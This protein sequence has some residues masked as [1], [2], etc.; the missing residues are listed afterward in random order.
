M[1]SE[2]QALGLVTQEFPQAPFPAGVVL[3][4][5]SALRGG[6]VGQ[7][8]HGP[9]RLRRIGLG[10]VASL[11][12]HQARVGNLSPLAERLQRPLPGVRQVEDEASETIAVARACTAMANHRPGMGQAIAQHL[13]A[14]TLTHGDIDAHR[15]RF[16]GPP[17]TRQLD[18]GQDRPQLLLALVDLGPVDLGLAADLA[19]AAVEHDRAVLGTV[20]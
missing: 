10:A 20:G 4:N 17:W 12:A 8:P 7:L 1:G 6:R 18:L 5:R 14:Q 15:S 13:F 2:P 9:H 16:G 3:H 19:Q 11:P